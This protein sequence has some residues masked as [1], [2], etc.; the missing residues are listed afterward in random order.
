MK[1]VVLNQFTLGLEPETPEDRK[2]LRELL[3]EATR[4]D[5]ELHLRVGVSN[6]STDHISDQSQ[7]H[8]RMFKLLLVR[9]KPTDVFELTS[10]AETAKV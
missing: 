9:S 8:G 6:P 4:S 7:G 3:D 2:I 5:G 10:T 1:P